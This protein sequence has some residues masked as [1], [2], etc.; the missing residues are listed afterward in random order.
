MYKHLKE[1]YKEDRASLF[2]VVPSD[3][4]R[5]NGQQLK[6]RTFP[7][8]IRKYFLTVRVPK[9]WHRLPRDAVEFPSLEIFK[10]CLDTV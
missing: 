4:T 2:S 3:K 9:H 1:E 7:L 10:S 8:N 6:H 5:G